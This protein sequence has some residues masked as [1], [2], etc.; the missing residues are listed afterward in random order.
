MAG[1]AGSNGLSEIEAVIE[2]RAP[3]DDPANELVWQPIEATRVTFFQNPATPGVWEGD[4][5]LTVPLTPGLFRLTLKELEWFRTD[6]AASLDPPRTA[7]SLA[8]RVVY[9]DVF[10]L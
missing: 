7:I 2:Q 5:P 10:A 9:A 3:A 4:V 6:D 8:R 1:S